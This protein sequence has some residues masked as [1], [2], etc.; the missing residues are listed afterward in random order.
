M[1]LLELFLSAGK[2]TLKLPYP[3]LSLAQNI[4]DRAMTLL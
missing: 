2:D 4:L 1:I 3:D